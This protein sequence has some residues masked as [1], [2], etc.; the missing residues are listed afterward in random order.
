MATPGRTAIKTEKATRSIL[1][2]VERLSI[3]VTVLTTL[4]QPIELS[5]EEVKFDEVKFFD[6]QAEIIKEIVNDLKASHESTAKTLSTIASDILTLKQDIAEL[7]PK[8][9]GRKPSIE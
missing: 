8:K 5:V 3:E 6:E 2:A 7:K 1:K 4:M 9:R